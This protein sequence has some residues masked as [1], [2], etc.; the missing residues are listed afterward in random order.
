MPYTRPNPNY[1]AGQINALIANQ[2]ERAR[3]ISMIGQSVID[4]KGASRIMSEL[5]RRRR[6][7]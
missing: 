2:F 3:S 5:T 6:T 1:I 4:G 7:I